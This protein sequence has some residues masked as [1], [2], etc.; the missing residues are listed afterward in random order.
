MRECGLATIWCSALHGNS[1]EIAAKRVS[2]LRIAIAD[3]DRPCG[4]TFA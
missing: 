3:L 1:W 4:F 2:R